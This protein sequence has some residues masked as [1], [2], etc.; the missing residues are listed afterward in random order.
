MVIGLPEN[1]ASL[2][3]FRAASPLD[4]GGA[5]IPMVLGPRITSDRNPQNSRAADF[6]RQ[7]CAE[8]NRV[9]W[10]VTRL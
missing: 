3:L 8:Q 10:D 4:L 6:V 5:G 9:P 2:H 7:N 1:K